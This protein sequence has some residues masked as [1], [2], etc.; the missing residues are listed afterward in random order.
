MPREHTAQLLITAQ[1]TPS[2]DVL[3][4]VVGFLEGPA[5]RVGIM[6]HFAVVAALLKAVLRKKSRCGRLRRYS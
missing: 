1:A 3:D 2:R 4:S 5:C 6:G